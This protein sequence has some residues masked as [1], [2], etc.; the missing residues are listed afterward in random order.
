MSTPYDKEQCHPAALSTE[1]YGLRKAELFKACF[2]R[3]LLLLKRN[4]FVHIFR[5]FQIISV[6]TLAMTIFFRTNM[7]HRNLDD[8][9][10]YFGVLF[11]GL[12]MNM[13]NGISGMPLTIEKLPVFYKQRDFMFYPAWAYSLPIW[14]TEIPFSFMESAAWVCLTYYTIGFA[15]TPSRF[16]RQFLLYVILHQTGLAIFRFIAALARNIIVADSVGALTLLM[17]FI[18]GGYVIS[19]ED[20]KGWWIW[21][22]WLSPLS[23]A[24]NAIA[25]NEFLA[26]RWQKPNDLI[27]W[28]LLKSRGIFTDSYWYWIGVAAL[29]GFA[30]TF[31]IFFILAMHYLNP[32]GKS[33]A[34][35]AE[36]EIEKDQKQ[37]MQNLPL[38]RSIS[39]STQQHHD[40]RTSGKILHGIRTILLSYHIL[41]CGLR[42]C[43]L[44]IFNFE[45]KKRGVTEQR[46]QLLCG[47]SGS[48]RPGILTAFVGESGAGKTTLMD[49]LA[50]RKTGGY[51]EG[52]ITISGYPKKQETF[53]RISGYCEQTDI[54]SPYVTVYESLVYSSWLRLGEEIDSETRKMFVNEVMDLVELNKLS[55]ALVGFPGVNGLSTEQRKRLT[56]A[57]ELVA[58]PSII[59]M[60]EPTTGLDARAAAIV[61]RTVRSTVDTGRTV[62]CTIHQPSIDI[63]EAFDELVLMKRGQLI[64]VGP[65]GHQC[66]TLVEYLEAIE[67]VAKI[68]PGY[69]P[70]TW[71]LEVTSINSAVRLGVD[72]AEIYRNS[73]LYQRNEALIQQISH[74]VPGSKDLSFQRQFAQ[75]FVVQTLACLWKQHWSYWRNPQYNSVRFFFTLASGLIFGTIFWGMGQKTHRQQDLL[76]AMG[77]M[78]SAILF[79]G[80]SNVV[81]VLPV[82]EVE[83]TVFYR[84]KAAG[85]YSALPYALAQVLIEVPYIFVQTVV[86]GVI[87]Y[88]LIDFHWTAA[89]FFWYFFMMF[90]TLLYTKYY[91]MMTVSLTPNAS[92]ALLLSTG[93]V[94]VWMVFSGF[95]IPRPR[96]PVWWRWYYWVSPFAWTLYG[97]VASQFGDISDEMVMADGSKQEV[98]KFL[99]RYFG[100]RQDFMGPVAVVTMSFAVLFALIFAIS[101]KTLNFQTR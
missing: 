100:Y 4:S 32:I 44:L 86:Y 41:I 35:V 75:P 51:I 71:M 15:P 98:N 101:I 96:I 49:V 54:H 38:K 87:V 93:F 37:E 85:M 19:R 18:F 76:N 14:I 61:M 55:G 53:A 68:T 65:L 46:L 21:G 80:L 12:A 81:S 22:Y 25:V 97:L 67:G 5:F 73:S 66:Q 6:A 24:Q 74:P 57:V 56:I 27:G 29:M 99:R 28:K 45:M 23:Y 79:L 91:G 89:K 39:M 2:D 69:N 95:I 48:F 9:S 60:D 70:A 82:V 50:G 3:Q 42:F 64:Y 77:S 72:F 52:S 84:E 88:A 10:I 59:F 11:L 34:I 47:V 1:K 90:F 58:N 43:K 17:M 30:V 26:T 20:I 8:G 33:Q 94:V 31:N 7:H 62:V 63:F 40:T 16:F 92:V 13:F 83:R 78:F 36:D